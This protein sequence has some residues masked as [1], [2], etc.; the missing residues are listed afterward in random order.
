MGIE[1]QVPPSERVRVY[2]RVGARE[3]LDAEN[4]PRPPGIGGTAGL[5]RPLDKGEAV[6]PIERQQDVLP[7]G[8]IVGVLASPHEHAGRPERED[9]L[10][11]GE[12]ARRNRSRRIVPRPHDHGHQARESDGGGDVLLDRTRHDAAPPNLG[13][14]LCR[15]PKHLA[16]RLRPAATLHVEEG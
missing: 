3:G 5:N 15:E 11:L 12:A 16:C 10:P 9:R 2:S 14:D 6:V 1:E 7:L 13:K 8:A 4:G